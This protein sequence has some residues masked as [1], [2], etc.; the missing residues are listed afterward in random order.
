MK[1]GITLVGCGAIGSF[2]AENLAMA[3]VGELTLVDGE[4]LRFG[5][6][7]R[8]LADESLVNANKAVAVAQMLHPRTEPS[9]CSI[10]AISRQLTSNN[11]AELIDGRDLV[12]DATANGRVLALLE[13]IATKTP[14]CLVS[15]ALHRAGAIARVDRLG[16]GT[17][18]AGTSASHPSKQAAP[19]VR[20][21]PAVATR[22][23]LPRRRP[24]WPQPRWRH[25]SSWTPS[26]TPG[27]VAS[28]ATPSLR[29]S[30]PTPRTQSTV[31]SA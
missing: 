13:A 8:H 4:K 2:L 25:A 15:V 18:A 14:L 16:N 23:R 28:T 9:G 27:P 26:S 6:S 17:C 29:R 10:K 5:N 12:V 1:R 31:A 7:A 22:S 19:K 21:S 30:W 11:A 3:G 20:P 24:S